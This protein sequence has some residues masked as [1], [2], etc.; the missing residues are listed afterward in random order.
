MTVV[1]SQVMEAARN[2]FIANKQFEKAVHDQLDTFTYVPKDKNTPSALKATVV[3]WVDYYM[4]DMC[5]HE[6]LEQVLKHL[7]AEILL[8]KPEEVGE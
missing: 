2:T 3:M 4:R 8:T 1:F 6:Q 7:G 5:T